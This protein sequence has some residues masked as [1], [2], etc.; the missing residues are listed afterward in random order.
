[1]YTSSCLS[2]IVLWN[3]FL[4]TVVAQELSAGICIDFHCVIAER[5]ARQGVVQ[6]GVE[7]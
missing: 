1:M 4:S 5:E 7:I 2:G 3:W 6:R